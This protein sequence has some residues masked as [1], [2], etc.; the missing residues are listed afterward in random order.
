MDG[1]LFAHAAIGGG[2]FAGCEG[3][4]GFDYCFP[5]VKLYVVGSIH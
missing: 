5:E 3:G 1:V 4:L 2:G